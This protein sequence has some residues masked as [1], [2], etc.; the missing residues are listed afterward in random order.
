MPADENPS[1]SPILRPP[2]EPTWRVATKLG[3]VGAGVG[4][5]CVLPFVVNDHAAANSVKAPYVQARNI[6]LHFQAEKGFW[7]K[8][9]DLASPGEQFAGFKLVALTE[10]LDACEIPGRWTFV[11][12]SAEGWPAIVFT[13]SVP[14]LSYERT[15]G[16]VDGWVDD[17]DPMTGD[18]R[19]RAGS[20]SL[21]LSAE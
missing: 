6:L 19:V 12:K 2:Q 10:A 9:F 3:L 18:M 7:P 21:R 13:P 11:A 5:A 4:L 14:G 8:D 17:G 16:V 1:T 15:L 20:A